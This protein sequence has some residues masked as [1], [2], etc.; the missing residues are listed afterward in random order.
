[1][2]LLIFIFSSRML[3][4]VCV[5]FIVGRALAQQESRTSKSLK[6][7]SS[8]TLKLIFSLLYLS[9]FAGLVISL[10]FLMAAC[11]KYM[12]RGAVARREAIWQNHQLI[13]KFREHMHERC[14]FNLKQAQEQFLHYYPDVHGF[15]C[16]YLKR[17]DLPRGLACSIIGNCI[18][19]I[20]N[21][22]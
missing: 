4:I 10:F 12:N 13:T 22:F 1:M 16:F 6:T 19:G 8:A 14:A 15:C 9:V 18:D 7:T 3:K 5:L 21:Q 17:M 2:V 11:K 20:L